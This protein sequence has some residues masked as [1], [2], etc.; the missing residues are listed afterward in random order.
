[1]TLGG[2]GGSPV[3]GHEYRQRLGGGMFDDNWIP[4]ANSANATSF[5]VD[6]LANGTTYFFQVRAVNVAGGSAADGEAEATPRT[7]PEKPTGLTAAA[8]NGVVTLSWMA[9]ATAAAR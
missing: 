4:I 5:T 6:S 2:D 7:M 8:G 1:M 3:T 9:A